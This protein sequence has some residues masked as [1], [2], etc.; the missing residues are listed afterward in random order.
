MKAVEA[1]WP[2]A[3]MVIGN[4]PFLGGSKKRG[5]LG[6]VYFEALETVFSERVAGGAD[7]VCFWFEKARLQLKSYGL[8]A[9]GFVSTQAI[10]AGSN[11]QV[12]QAIVRD[13]RIFDAWSDEPWINDG[14]AVRVSMVSFGWGIGCVLNGQQVSAIS[15]DLRGS[16]SGDLTL[17]SRLLEN[18]NISFEGAQKNGPFDI[19]GVTARAWLTTPNPNLKSSALVLRPYLNAADVTGRA[20]DAWMIDFH[21]FSEGEASQFDAPFS[22]VVRVVK[23]VR[24]TK[25]EPYLSRKYWLLKRPAVDLRQALKPISRYI[26][27]PR[28]AKHRFFTFVLVSVLPDSRLNSIARADHVTLG[29][30]SSKMHEVWSLVT[31]SRIGVGNDPIYNAKSCFETF[32]FPAGLTPKDTASQQT[33]TL[34][35]SS[36]IP[37]ALAPSVLTS[38]AAIAKAAKQLNDL[39][40]NWLNPPE[41]TDRIPEVTPLGMTTSPYPDR[42]IA[43]PGH[44]KDLAERTLTKLYNQRPAWLDAAHKQLDAAVAAAYGWA[45]YTPDM[46]DEEILKRLL[47]L[48]LERAGVQ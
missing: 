13:V 35:D 17:A 7:L 30:L 21:G 18:L 43:K 12:L 41:W 44:E 38:A 11:R 45:D 26:I 39:R 33:E 25:K 8:G 46:P 36:V 14:A 34:P 31:C 2:K 19:D 4:P 42:I 6:D 29:L 47:A 9:A 16:I 48:N 20:T 40:E 24:E 5:E 27:T 37:A 3:S 28:V 22:Y 15:A 10:R 23:P 32:P 1:A